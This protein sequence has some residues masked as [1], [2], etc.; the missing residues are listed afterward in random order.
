MHGYAAGARALG[1]TSRRGCEVAGDRV[2]GG[3]V[4][5]VVT[6]HGHVATG[7]VVCA[8][9]AWS[10]ALGEMA[11]V[12]LPVTPLRRQV[13]FTEPV[14]GLPADLPMTIDFATGFYFHRE[15]PGL[16]MGMTDPDEPPGFKLDTTTAGSRALTEIA[17]A[18][19]PRRERR[20]SP[21]AGP[22]CTR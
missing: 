14:P 1:A 9:G 2:D 6:T 3:E 20:R 7:T 15:G 17:S 18:A 16:L 22:A 13:L 11:G 8:A 4:A 19:P 12:E 10:R 5:A 21:A